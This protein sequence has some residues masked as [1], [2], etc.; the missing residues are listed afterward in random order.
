MAA[1]KRKSTTKLGTMAF[2][3]SWASRHGSQPS[4]FLPILALAI[5]ALVWSPPVHAS[6]ETFT[7]ANVAVDATA[8]TAAT[9]R[10]RAIQEGQRRAFAR[11]L[12]RI[13]PQDQRAHMPQLSDTAIGDLVR[14]F[15]IAG[16]KTSSVRYIASLTVRFKPD[17]VRALLRRNSVAYA[18][19]PSKTVLVLPV[20]D[21]GSGAVLF[22][23]NQWRA[24]WAAQLP[25]D[26][27]VPFVLPRDDGDDATTITA[28]Q[29]L[30]S[31][32]AALRAIAARYGVS[33]VLVVSAKLHPDEASGRD[34]LDVSASR[35]GNAATEENMVTTFA[36]EANDPDD[37]AM[38]DRAVTA[39]KT[40]IEDSWKQSSLLHFGAQ[41]QLAVRV[42]LGSLDALTAVMRGLDGLAPVQH[43]DV[44]RIS[45][46]EA[47]LEL[48]FV[49]DA[50]QLA[51][52]LAQRDLTLGQDAGS[53][54]LQ[55]AVGRAGARQ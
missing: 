41:Q 40:R 13:T 38:F 9:A 53:Y 51:L 12:Q 22:A 25:A 45:R 18:E 11:L 32:E 24:A 50:D 54:I 37:G 8:N 52:L 2:I 5:L 1:G 26:G 21:D 6:E 10:D 20:Y 27:L 14:D 29:A 16:E 17:D 48:S 42:P 31:D 23:D 49:G 28:E 15:E 30:A 3:S 19:T 44:V 39:I 43:V 4:F 55:P 35:L 47:D 34:A 33:D 7:I 46:D 36:P